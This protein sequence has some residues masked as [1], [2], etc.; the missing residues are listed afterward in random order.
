MARIENSVLSSS[1]LQAQEDATVLRSLVVPLEEEI[2]AL[3]DKLRETDAEL[4]KYKND[5]D[6]TVRRVRITVVK[7]GFNFAN[8]IG[9]LQAETNEA[10]NVVVK[11]VS[12]R[13]TGFVRAMS[14]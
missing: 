13:I 7:Y 8:L 10:R 4:M 6:T 14:T 2:R 9:T 12:R 5:A 3:K 11:K 1:V